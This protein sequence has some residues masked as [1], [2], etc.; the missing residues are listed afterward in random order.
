MN[1]SKPEVSADEVIQ[2]FG[3]TIDARQAALL[4][5]AGMSAGAGYPS[6][7]QLVQAA[8]GR[9]GVARVED[10]PLWAQYVEN[11]QPDGAAAL[12]DEIVLRIGGVV[13]RPLESHRLLARLPISDVWSTNYD[14][15]IE[16]ADPALEVIAQDV[17]LAERRRGARRLYK[18]HGSIPHGAAV[19]VGG[20]DQLVIT[21]DDYSRYPTTH[22]RLWRLLQAQFLTSSF[23]F[24]GFS[25]TDPNFDAVFSLVRHAIADRVMPHYA[26]LK[27]PDDDA[28]QF[29]DKRADLTNIG[30]NV[31]E[32]ADY[33]DVPQLLRRLVARTLPLRVFVAG[34]H[35]DPSDVAWGG[36]VYPTKADA[37]DTDA[38]AE[39]LGVALAAAGVPGVLAAGEVGAAAGYAYQRSLTVYEPERFT[40]LRRQ[41]REEVTAPR[42]RLGEIRFTGERPSELRDRAFAAV[43]CVVVISG[44]RGTLEEVERARQQGMSVIPLGASGGAAAQ[45]WADMR[46]DLDAYE[47]GQQPIDDRLFYQLGVVDPDEAV[48]AAVRFVRIGLFM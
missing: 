9:V 2:D 6:W 34:S 22:P 39:K 8:A 18:M 40:L 29:D 12:L 3:G 48:A 28:G 23:L 10:L 44:G 7:E 24:L 1:N 27:R 31:V 46:A 37:S 4:V 47:I 35:R 41:S 21:R 11:R 15:L 43:R 36:G 13:P 17:E 45:I 20:R 30:V 5:G 38:L 14:P 32:I 19:P 42:L 26:L 33:D 25:L 16:T